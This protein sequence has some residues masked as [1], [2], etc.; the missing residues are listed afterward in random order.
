VAALG[1]DLGIETTTTDSFSRLGKG[2]NPNNGIGGSHPNL[3]SKQIIGYI[4]T[5]LILANKFVNKLG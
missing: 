4:W 1:F 2:T 5:S 3:K